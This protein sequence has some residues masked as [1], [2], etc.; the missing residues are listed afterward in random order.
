MGGPPP[1]RGGIGA[2]RLTIPAPPTGGMGAGRGPGDGL[3]LEIWKF[4]NL[5]FLIFS[6]N[7]LDIF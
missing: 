7:P 4:I 2:G 1:P 6:G 3:L 5:F